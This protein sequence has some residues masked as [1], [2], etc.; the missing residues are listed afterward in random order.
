MK[1]PS[2]SNALRPSCPAVE[3][4]P[5]EHVAHFREKHPRSRKSVTRE[6]VD[7]GKARNLPC[8][9]EL[10]PVRLV[11]VV[12]VAAHELTGERARSSSERPLGSRSRGQVE[13]QLVQRNARQGVARSHCDLLGRALRR[14]PAVL[15]L[16]DTTQAVGFERRPH[17]AVAALP[18]EAGARP[19]S[20]ARPPACACG[21][22]SERSRGSRSQRCP[23][24]ECR[25][26]VVRKSGR[27][28]RISPVAL[29]ASAQLHGARD[30]LLRKGSDCS[31]FGSVQ[32]CAG[33]AH[34]SSI[35]EGARLPWLPPAVERERGRGLPGQRRLRD[36][37][38]D[39]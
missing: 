9:V 15:L 18:F 4:P 17:V 29:A 35:G 38:C 24:T 12:L 11:R 20:R 39:K 3:V 25:P 28:P 10:N 36:S 19:S 16:S 22:S 2:A 27:V 26:V 8:A 33:S 23:R 14:A 21:R 34:P 7:H 37:T 13:F 6:D 5:V 31:A 30:D 32:G 1:R